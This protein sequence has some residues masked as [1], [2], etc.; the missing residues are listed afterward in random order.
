MANILASKIFISS[1][2]QDKI[3]SAIQDPIN[4]ELVQ[5]MKSYL[6]EDF[7]APEYLKD[8]KTIKHIKSL[9][10]LADINI[11]A[12]EMETKV[13]E[14]EILKYNMKELSKYDIRKYNT[15]EELFIENIIKQCRTNSK[16]H[17]WIK[18]STSPS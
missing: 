11:L 2:R 8:D 14:G 12:K 5:Q 13:L 1:S 3:L 4:S 17:Y 6:D 15:G 16:F 7:I 10:Q 9:D 18:K